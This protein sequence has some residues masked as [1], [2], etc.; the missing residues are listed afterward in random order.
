M[1]LFNKVLFIK[2]MF[3]V[4]ERHVSPGRFIYVTK[5]IIIIF[6]YIGD[7][8]RVLISYGIYKT[9]LWRF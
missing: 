1:N 9:N 3:L 5:L 8:T 6:V 4:R 2:Y 7:L